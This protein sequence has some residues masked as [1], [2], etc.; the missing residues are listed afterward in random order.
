M[1]FIASEITWILGLFKE[2]KVEINQPCKLISD[3]K[4]VMMIVANSIFHERTKRIE[5][6]YRFIREKIQQCFI[7]IE[8][9]PNL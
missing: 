4:S 5:I 3:S 7:Q 2:L 9:I 6:D 8:Y 1:A